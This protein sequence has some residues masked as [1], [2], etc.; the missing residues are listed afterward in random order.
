MPIYTRLLTPTD[1]GVLALIWMT[2][3]VVTIF[4]GSRIAIGVFHFYHKAEGD[5]ARRT[6]LSTALLLLAA[7]FGVAAALTLAAAPAIANAVFGETGIYV[8][9][10]RLAAVSML[11][12]SLIVV[13]NALFQL[14]Q[15]SIRFVSFSLVRL[16]LQLVGVPG[17][18]STRGWLLLSRPLAH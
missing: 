18:W 7:T 15:K 1:Y 14:Q 13:P 3:E 9:Y 17:L 4:A 8:T 11:F 10:I 16:G 6:V 2:F 12:E 5:E